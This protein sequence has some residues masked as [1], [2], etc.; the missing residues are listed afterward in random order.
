MIRWPLA[1]VA[2]TGI[3]LGMMGAPLYVLIAVSIAVTAGFVLG[4]AAALREH[5]MEARP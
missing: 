2:L 3:V 5:R 1:T 4:Y